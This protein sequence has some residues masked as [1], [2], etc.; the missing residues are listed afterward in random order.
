M[1][2]KCR[3]YCQF[4][5]VTQINY[6]Q[7]YLAD[8][9]PYFSHDAINRYLR[10]DNVGQSAVWASIK[11]T[12]NYSDNSCIIFDDSVLDKRYRPRWKWSASSIAATN[13]G[14]SKA[15]ALSTASMLTSAPGTTGLST[16]ESIIL[17]T[18]AKPSS[19]CAG[20]VRQRPHLQKTAVSYRVDGLLVRHPGFDALY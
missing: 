10:D 7:T 20:D 6:T 18:T 11:N 15:S 9:H 1:S 3:D 19:S 13:T 12:I 16:G 4:L 8:H 2:L 17:E 14:S 5:L